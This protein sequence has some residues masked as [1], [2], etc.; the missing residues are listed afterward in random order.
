MHQ[1]RCN[2]VDFVFKNDTVLNGS[3]TMKGS[4]GVK[5]AL[6]KSAIYCKSLLKFISNDSGATISTFSAP[7]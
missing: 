3:M 7:C 5:E 1:E 6:G 4:D 2:I